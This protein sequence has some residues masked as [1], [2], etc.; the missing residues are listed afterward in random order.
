MVRG[1]EGGISSTDKEE[2]AKVWNIERRRFGKDWSRRLWLFDV[3]IWTVM[4]YA[5]EIWG[6]KESKRLERI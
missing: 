6:W 2:G 4:R 1:L 5:V 3:F